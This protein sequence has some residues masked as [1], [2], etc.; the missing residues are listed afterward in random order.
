MV[1]KK[2]TPRPRKGAEIPIMRMTQAQ[3]ARARK[4]SVT[5][6]ADQIVIG[7]RIATAR[8]K[9]EMTQA[10]LATALDVSNARIAHW[11][12]GRGLPPAVQIPI[13][14]D[15]LGL[16]CNQLLTGRR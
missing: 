13:L 6:P 15:I 1:V 14:A 8:E 9:L 10:E 16:T 2:K 5:F 4:V 11:E 12:R 3:L 7:R